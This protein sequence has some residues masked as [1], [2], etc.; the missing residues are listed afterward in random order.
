M[1]KSFKEPIR[2]G[3]VWVVLAI[4][5]LAG[6]PWYLPKGGIHPIIFGMP[7]WAVI[8]VLST[9]A[10]AVFLNYVVTNY[11]DMEGMKEKND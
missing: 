9:I 7:Y 8:S 4:I 6:V 5:I 10:L 11:W 1:Q 3:W 2:F